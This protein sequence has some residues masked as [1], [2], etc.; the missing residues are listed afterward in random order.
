MM[1]YY[2][3]CHA[4]P[5]DPRVAHLQDKLDAVKYLNRARNGSQLPAPPVD[6]VELST[7]KWRAEHV[8]HGLVSSY[9]REGRHPLYWYTRLDGGL[10]AA[11]EVVIW[12]EHPYVS[13]EVSS[14]SLGRVSF[15]DGVE[16]AIRRRGDALLSPCYNYV[17][18]EKATAEKQVMGWMRSYKR[19][20]NVFIFYMVGR[21]VDWASLPLYADGRLAAEGYAD[22]VMKP[23]AFVI[24]YAPHEKHPHLRQTYSLGDVHFCK[25]LDPLADCKDAAELNGTFV[26]HKVLDSGKWY[27]KIDTSVPLNRTG[28]YTFEIIAE[29]L[30]AQGRK[31]SIMHYTIEAP[32]KG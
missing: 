26:V 5:A 4:R 20:W 25:Y 2:T 8:K 16:M 7:P 11:E 19:V 17:G 24:R 14:E 30:R 9:D 23:A 18:M 21:W 6:L 13:S 15:R 10:Y 28:L 32:P 31:C 27:I 29:D 22:P 1:L 3:T 12:I